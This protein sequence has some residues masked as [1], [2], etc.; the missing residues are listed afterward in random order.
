MTM[1]DQI[2]TLL[3]AGWVTPLDALQKAGCLSLSQRVGELERSGTAIIRD[4]LKLPNG[5]RVRRYRIGRSA[6]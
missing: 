5:K 6:S 1:L 4:W 3:R 2:I